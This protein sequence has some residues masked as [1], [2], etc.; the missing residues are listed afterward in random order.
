MNKKYFVSILVVLALVVCG[1]Q[2]R[3][4][5]GADKFGAYKNKA[6]HGALSNKNKKNDVPQSYEEWVAKNGV[7]EK[8]ATAPG[9]NQNTTRTN[10]VQS[11]VNKAV[12]PQANSKIIGEAIPDWVFDNTAPEDELYDIITSYAYPVFFSYA[13]CPIGNAMKDA[14]INSISNAGAS[15]KFVEKADLHAQGSSSRTFCSKQR[16]NP[17]VGTN[18]AVNYLYQ[19]CM[20]KICIINPMKRRIVFVEPDETVLTNKLKELMHNW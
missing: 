16:E 13:D 8:R 2:F 14:V 12:Q 3:N 17:E 4:N 15:S 5:S 1:C 6:H 20:D 7:P 10:P 9:V 18:C 11:T 19:N